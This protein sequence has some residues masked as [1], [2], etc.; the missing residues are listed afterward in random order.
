MHRTARQ[1]VHSVCTVSSSGEH[2]KVPAPGRES[3]RVSGIPWGFQSDDRLQGAVQA[4]RTLLLPLHCTVLPILC[5]RGSGHV[6]GGIF[7][8]YLYSPWYDFVFFTV[9]CKVYGDPS[10]QT[11]SRV[12][13]L[14]LYIVVFRCDF[15]LLLRYRAGKGRKSHMSHT[16][17]YQ[18]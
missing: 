11:P 1:R 12:I 8:R 10:H 9:Y 3:Q 14:T 17:R 6:A 4:P 2:P 18:K 13:L 7:P 15:L 16:V 5:L